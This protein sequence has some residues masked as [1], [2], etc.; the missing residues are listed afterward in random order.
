MTKTVLAVA[1][2]Q[3]ERCLHTAFMPLWGLLACPYMTVDIHAARH[4]YQS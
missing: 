4:N 1:C 2:T 3:L